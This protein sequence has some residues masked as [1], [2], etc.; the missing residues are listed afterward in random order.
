MPISRTFRE[1][2]KCDACGTVTVPVQTEI[3]EGC[4]VPSTDCPPGWTRVTTAPRV[5]A[6]GTGRPLSEGEAGYCGILSGAL[7]AV[8]PD[9]DV[10]VL[11]PR[12][13]VLCPAHAWLSV[14]VQAP[15]AP[16]FIL[17]T[18]LLRLPGIWA[19]EGAVAEEE[20]ALQA[21][22]AEGD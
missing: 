6:A 21:A 19:G 3:A 16:V 2:W 14:D 5:K 9:G 4:G 7:D 8:Q 11:R 18:R 15:G 10:A 17:Q 12:E 1:T 20:P 22:D 13:L